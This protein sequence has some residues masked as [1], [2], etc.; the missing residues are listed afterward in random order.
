MVSPQRTLDGQELHSSMYAKQGSVVFHNSLN[1]MPTS[2][3]H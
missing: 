3:Q 1:G 2:K